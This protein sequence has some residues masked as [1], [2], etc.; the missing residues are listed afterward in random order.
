MDSVDYRRLA[1]F[2]HCSSSY[3]AIAFALVIG[4][5]LLKHTIFRA[6]I[7]SIHIP[8]PP[9][10]ESH[11]KGETLTTPSI[12]CPDPSLIQCYCPA[13]GQLLDR[14]RAATEQDVDVAIQ[15]AKIA[16]LKWSRT[17]FQERTR[18]LRVL[19]KFILDHQGCLGVMIK[20]TNL[21]GHCQSFMP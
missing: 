6:P 18:V 21:R 13:T 16:Q 11:W 4:L 2:L 3:A 7:P 14:V 1:A 5:V 17:S 12:T 9:Q 19:L 20:L 10:A 15:K 8:L